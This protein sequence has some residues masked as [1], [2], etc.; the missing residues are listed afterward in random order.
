MFLIVV[1]A[2]SKWMEVFP[3][4]SAT[5]EA[6]I[7]MLRVVCARWGLPKTIVSDN[8]QC[9]V[10][11]TFNPAFAGVLRHPRLAGGGGGGALNAPTS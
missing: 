7:E 1:D 5:A 2:F 3:L 10:G 6:T 11:S 8:A 9:F 4:R